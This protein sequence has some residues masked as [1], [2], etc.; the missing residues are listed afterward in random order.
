MVATPKSSMR[1]GKAVAARDKALPA[2]FISLMVLGQGGP[3][4][5]GMFVQP[6]APEGGTGAF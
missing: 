3:P 2:K 6:E 1:R 4:V 5:P